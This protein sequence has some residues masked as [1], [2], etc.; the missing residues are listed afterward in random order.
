[1]ILILGFFGNFGENRNLCFFHMEIPKPVVSQ[2]VGGD[3]ICN[4]GEMALLVT[5]LLCQLQ[6]ELLRFS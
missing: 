3:Q 6:R 2:L 5:T 1:M 4:D